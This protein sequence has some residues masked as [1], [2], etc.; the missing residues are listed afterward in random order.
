[1][2]KI[3][4]CLLIVALMTVFGVTAWAAEATLTAAPSGAQPGGTMTVTVGLEEGATVA[5]GELYISYDTDTFEYVD[6]TS[7]PLVD[8]AMNVGN[9]KDGVFAFAFATPDG[10]VQ[11]GT[12]VTVTF[13]VDSDA[14]GEH[15]FYCYME[16]LVDVDQNP[17]DC[18]Q[19]EFS[20]TP[21]GTVMTG[22]D[23]TPV[24]SV[25]AKG[26][27]YVVMAKSFEE[28]AWGGIVIGILA[29]VAIIGV[30]AL[31]VVMVSRASTKKKEEPKH[32]SILDE[33]SKKLLDLD[34]D[35]SK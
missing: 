14:K 24:T 19:V 25:D 6:Y 16:N 22:T 15:D 18:D 29:I 20:V 8:S 17:I 2:K 34:D 31:F 21:T 32:Q 30:G 12:M 5:A 35:S 28:S 27:T 11:K 9:L 26:N 33:E 10:I 3:V 4:A 7:G 23:V 1:M 13:K